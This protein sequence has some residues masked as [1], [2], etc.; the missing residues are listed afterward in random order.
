MFAQLCEVISNHWIV[1]FKCMTLWY[2]NYILIKLFFKK[3]DYEF[4]QM[5]SFLSKTNPLDGLNGETWKRTGK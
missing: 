3:K 1:Y 5:H 2:V 4:T